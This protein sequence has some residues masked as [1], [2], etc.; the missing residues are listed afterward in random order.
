MVEDDAC[1][2]W[3]QQLVRGPTALTEYSECNWFVGVF[4]RCKDSIE[5]LLGVGSAS[6]PFPHGIHSVADVVMTG[7]NGVYG[8]ASMV[9]KHLGAAAGVNGKLR[10]ISPPDCTAPLVAFE[11]ALVAFEGAL[12]AFEG[13]LVAFEGALVTFEGAAGAAMAGNGK[14]RVISPPDCTAPL[15]AFEGAAAKL[16][17]ERAADRHE[18][19]H[20]AQLA[21]LRAADEREPLRRHGASVENKATVRRAMSRAEATAHSMAWPLLLSWVC[22][23]LL[24]ARR[25]RERHR[26]SEE[27]ATS[28]RR[29]RE[30]LP[31]VGAVTATVLMSGKFEAMEAKLELAR[32]DL[33][34]TKWRP[35]AL[36]SLAATAT[37]TISRSTRR[38]GRRGGR[39]GHGRQ[40]ARDSLGRFVR[41]P[42][43]WKLEWL[44]SPPRWVRACG[45]TTDPDEPGYSV[46]TDPFTPYF[47]VQ[48][49]RSVGYSTLYNT[50]RDPS[51]WSQPMAAHA[52][53]EPMHG[54]LADDDDDPL[55]V[56]LPLPSP[57]V[58][59]GHLAGSPG[60]GHRV[61][62]RHGQARDNS[63]SGAHVGEPDAPADLIADSPGIGH[64]VRA[65]HE[66]A[67]GCDDGGEPGTG[68][69]PG[70]GAEPEHALHDGGVQ[71]DGPAADA[72]A[73]G[74]GIRDD[75]FGD[76][77]EGV[78][79]QDGIGAEPDSIGA[80]VHARHADGVDALA[81][82]ASPCRRGRRDLERC[83]GV[84]LAQAPTSRAEHML[85]QS[86]AR[87]IQLGGEDFEPTSTRPADSWGESVWLSEVARQA[88]KRH[89]LPPPHRAEVA[90]LAQSGA[91]RGRLTDVF[92]AP[93]WRRVGPMAWVT[94]SVL[95]GAGGAVGVRDVRAVTHIY[96]W[97]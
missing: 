64:R 77:I 80:R 95:R 44:H 97:G 84:G 31:M 83:N 33:H 34:S 22:A 16:T 59:D 14:L 35:A 75:G 81:V 6:S 37:E 42:P 61:R 85:V 93:V 3:Q 52:D 36:C 86:R 57:E 24:L 56:A 94:G 12:V 48:L 25:S 91:T 5:R 82:C 45:I 63:G 43:G 73:G 58:D 66:Q 38:R 72:D 49:L 79:D 9:G 1:A 17:V 26:R 68:T 19:P 51:A 60:I 10:A 2:Q 55:L 50:G 96:R 54:R 69:E 88:Y 8:A 13:A 62:A 76:L 70:A 28:A 15:V 47:E 11:G 46:Y 7:A 32:A 4:G 87:W 78:G 92:N 40:R 67:R 39:R 74:F 21:G 27:A 23:L 65:R 18:P 53:D 29:A 20:P 71:P 41:L 30:M 90:R 89:R